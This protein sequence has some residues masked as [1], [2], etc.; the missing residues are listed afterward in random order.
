MDNTIGFP[1]TYPIYPVERCHLF[2]QLAQ[3]FYFW[4]EIGG[5]GSVRPTKPTHEESLAP[6]VYVS[7]NVSKSF[8]YCNI[9]KPVY[10][11]H[12]LLR[13]ATEN[14]GKLSGDRNIQGDR[15]RAVTYR[16][17]QRWTFICKI[18][19]NFFF[20]WNVVHCLSCCWKRCITV[21]WRVLYVNGACLT[22]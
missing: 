1:N 20:A 12:P 5:C 21:I 19:I 16:F 9:V 8:I 6:G 18:K 11:S 3:R 2:E 4:R 22:Y 10:N 13:K 14:F 17:M 7:G 15:F